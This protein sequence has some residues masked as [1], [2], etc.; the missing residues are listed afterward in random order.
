MRSLLGRMLEHAVPLAVVCFLM[1]GSAVAGGL[2]TSSQIKDGTITGKDV[3]DRSL[4]VKDFQGSIGSPGAIG[5][6]GPVGPKG[7]AGSPGSPGAG[8]DIEQVTKSTATNSEATKELSVQ[9]PN[10]PVL[11]GGYVISVNNKEIR[12]VRNYAVA[13]NEWL[14][15]AV[16][17][18]GETVSWHVTVVAVCAK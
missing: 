7:D 10:G 15:R 13:S 18:A 3:K 17:D 9:C 2:I 4:S 14:V 6:V 11:S 8:V 1:A 12:A 5:P 16:N